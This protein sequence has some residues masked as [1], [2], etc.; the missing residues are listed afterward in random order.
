MDATGQIIGSLFELNRIMRHRMAKLERPT[1]LNMHQMHALVT[2]QEHPRCTMSDVARYLH[3]TQASATPL[4]ARLVRSGL[5][6]RHVDR[7]NRKLVRVSL[8]PRG[9]SELKKAMTLCHTHLRSIFSKI[10]AKDQKTMVAILTALL[11]AVAHS[12]SSAS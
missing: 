11:K 7:K 8:T 12:S 5:V 2:M 10:P 1:D 3:I 9:T 6:Q 4:I